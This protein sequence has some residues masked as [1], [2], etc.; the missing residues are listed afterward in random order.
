[1]D[2]KN[3]LKKTDFSLTDIISIYDFRKEDILFVLKKAAE[4]EKMTPTEKSLLLKNKI[5]A[6]MFFEPSTRTRLSFETAANSLGAKIV[7]FSEA[8][9]TSAKKGESFSDTIKTISNYA[10]ILVIRHPLSGT[11]RRAAEVSNK[12]V[13][14]GGDGPNQHPTQTLLDL[15]TIKKYVGRLE[16][17]KIG[18]VGDLKYGRT[19]HSLATA[20]THFNATQY[21]ISPESLKMP[22]HI[23][24]EVKEKCKVFETE[25][26]EKFI[27]EVDVLYMTRIQK[28]RFPDQL[29]YEKVKDAYVL[30]NASLKNA[31]KTMKVMH[32]LPRVNE[33]A[34][35]VDE[36]EH[37]IYFQQTAA[38]IPVREALLEILS[39]VK[40]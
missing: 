25:E 2:S 33:I 40:K 11:A 21:Y 36:T 38:G 18:F 4:I 39:K 26:L 29:E 3:S 34:V 8:G 19:V 13:L 7:G 5:V 24:D 35:E 28:E 30:T 22:K 17:L 1:M 15:Y 16:D 9:V 23:S 37:A 32:P 6:S 20:L 31:K 14:N 12:P 10:D 27:P